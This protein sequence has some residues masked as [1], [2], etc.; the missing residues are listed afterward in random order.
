[1]YSDKR[2]TA[3]YPWRASLFNILVE[4][5][6]DVSLVHDVKVLVRRLRSM[7]LKAAVVPGTLAVE[8]TR[9]VYYNDWSSLFD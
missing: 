4:G 1:M 7:L 3:I 8:E 6:T 9:S 5:S 2:K